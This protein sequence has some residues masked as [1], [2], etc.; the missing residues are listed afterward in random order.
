MAIKLKKGVPKKNY[1]RMSYRR[2]RERASQQLAG[3]SMRLRGLVLKEGPMEEGDIEENLRTGKFRN[4]MFV[5]DGFTVMFTVENYGTSAYQHLSI[6]RKDRYPTW[7][8]IVL[9]RSLF[10]DDDD[11]VIQ[12]IP[13][14]SNYVNVHDNCFHLWLD[15]SGPRM[16]WLS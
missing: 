13:K 11:E 14:E 4:S 9:F 2:L 15:I 6:S 1:G 16:T 7:D 8:E 3:L 10:F 12:V 5:H